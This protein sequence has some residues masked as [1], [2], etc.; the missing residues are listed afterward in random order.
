L[1]EKHSAVVVEIR[2]RQQTPADREQCFPPIGEGQGTDFL[3]CGIEMSSE[4]SVRTSGIDPA[5]APLRRAEKKVLVFSRRTDL[6]GERHDLKTDEEV[7]IQQ[8][9]GDDSS[10]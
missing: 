7:K 4:H 8:H 1:N 10:I 6:P 9:R 5:G 2:P 3:S